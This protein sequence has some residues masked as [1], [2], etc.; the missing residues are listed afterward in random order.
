MTAMGCCLGVLCFC[1]P[2]DAMPLSPAEEDFYVAALQGEW[3]IEQLDSS[4]CYFVPYAS[5][6]ARVHGNRCRMTNEEGTPVLDLTNDTLLFTRAASTGQVPLAGKKGEI[7]DI[8]TITY[9]IRWTRSVDY[10]SESEQ[11]VL[12]GQIRDN[13]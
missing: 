12:F 6:K 13:I 9:D 4:C 2:T 3:D 1:L 8:H 7:V 10:V 5:R 11:I